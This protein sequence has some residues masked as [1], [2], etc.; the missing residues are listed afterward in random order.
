MEQYISLDMFVAVED[1]KTV[2]IFGF[3]E[4]RRWKCQMFEKVYFI[5][6]NMIVIF[7]QSGLLG[8]GVK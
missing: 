7:F 3:W 4:R 6:I 8:R 2:V 1:I 5:I